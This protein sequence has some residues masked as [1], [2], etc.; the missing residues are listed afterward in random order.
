LSN[1]PD[2]V[3]IEKYKTT[4][5]QVYISALYTR[6]VHLIYGVC[7]KYLKRKETSEDMT[8]RMY[9]K[10]LSEIKSSTTIRDFKSWLFILIRNACLSQ[11]RKD[12]THRQQ[13]EKWQVEKKSQDY[14]MENEGLLRLM[15][16]SLDEELEEQLPIILE[17]LAK[18]QKTCIRL[19]FFERKSYQEI[20]QKTGYSFK[21]VKSFL[22]NG[23]RN[24]FQKLKK[25]S[26]A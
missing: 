10:L 9:E 19:F 1:I 15:D 7:L 14:F 5:E 4:G 18:G 21:E 6:Y 22:Q 26:N 25:Y 2:Q 8:A 16:D 3:L 23:K 24:L 20:A 13:F 17:Q 11:V 12:K